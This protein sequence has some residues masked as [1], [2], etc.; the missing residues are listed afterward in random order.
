MFKCEECGHL[1]EEGE[2][3]IIIERHGFDYGDGEVFSYCP[4]CGGTYEEVKA[5]KIC[6]SYEDMKPGEDYC[7]DCKSEV[8]KTFEGLLDKYFSVEQR[9]LLNVIY[10]GEEL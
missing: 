8:R 10:E 4:R 5:C 6:G 7:Q 1:F 3:E 2:Q 9:A